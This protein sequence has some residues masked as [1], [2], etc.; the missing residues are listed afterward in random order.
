VEIERSSLGKQ[1][2]LRT[3]KDFDALKEHGNACRDPF[4]TVLV[5]AAEPDDPVPTT[6]YG[7]ICSRKL[8]HSA[9]IRNR[10]RRL[11]TETFRLC[12]ENI[13]PCSILIIPR[14]AIFGAKQQEVQ[15]HLVRTLK[16]A[17]LIR[18]KH[19]APASSAKS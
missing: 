8:H 14:R 3:R 17:G 1:E 5:R 16:K 13:L 2:K 19:P 4:F 10:A 9:V 18:E 11:I 6:R 12:K 7:I 15:D